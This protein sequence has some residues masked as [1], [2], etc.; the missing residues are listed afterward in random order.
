[1]QGAQLHS[2]GVDST[3]E[4]AKLDSLSKSY[5]TIAISTR[6]H[7][8]SEIGHSP[9]MCEQKANDIYAVIQAVTKDSVTVLGFSDGAYTGYKL[10]SIYPGSVKKLIAM[11][12][13]E[14]V[15]GLRKVN[16]NVKEMSKL[17]SLYFRQQLALMPESGR[18]QEYLTNWANFYNTMTA[19]KELFAS[20]HCPAEIRERS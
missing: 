20:I 7:G 19:S 17:N 11:G 6:G 2:G 13:G 1:M 14:Q 18:L 15:P 10:A 16:L 9:V 8:K 3:Y 4:M 12:A 5:Q